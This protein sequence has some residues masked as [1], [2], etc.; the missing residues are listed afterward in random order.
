[1]TPPHYTNSQNSISILV[2]LNFRQ[3]SFQFVPPA[4]KLNNPNLES[5]EHE[6][7]H[8]LESVQHVLESVQ[9]ELESVQYELE[10][11]NSKC[12]TNEKMIEKE[13]EILLRAL[14]LL[15]FGIFSMGHLEKTKLSGSSCSYIAS[16]GNLESGTFLLDTDGKGNLAPYEVRTWVP[17]LCWH[18][19]SYLI[20]Y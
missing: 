20:A 16:M 9:H 17:N 19:F 12:E 14:R 8:G 13:Q 1:M 6:F 4:W 15:N 3:I 18:W 7:H 11:I 10:S 2:T 5:V